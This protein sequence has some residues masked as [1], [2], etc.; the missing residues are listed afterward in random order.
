ME[1]EVR[2]VLAESVASDEQPERTLLE[3]MRAV[4]GVGLTEKDV[5]LIASMRSG[6]V[7]SAAIR[8]G[9]LWW[10]EDES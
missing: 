9:Q 1:S 10:L 5:E 3:A 8:P 2:Q 7:S 6:D 4:P